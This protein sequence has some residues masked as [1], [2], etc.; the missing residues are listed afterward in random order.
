MEGSNVDILIM[1]IHVPCYQHYENWLELVQ[2]LGT[3]RFISRQF[4]SCPFILRQVT[5]MAESV[6]ELL[7]F[8]V[9]VR[10]WIMIGVKMEWKSHGRWNIM[11]WISDANPI[12]SISHTM[13][14]RQYDLPHFQSPLSVYILMYV[15][16]EKKCK[17]LSPRGEEDIFHIH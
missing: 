1:K 13:N 16:T 7:L 15:S 4:T 12:I 14:K 3:G 5:A 8:A 11:R 9:W 10:V 2:A 6:L 17:N